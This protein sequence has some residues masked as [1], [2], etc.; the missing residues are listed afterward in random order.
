MSTH[1][2]IATAEDDRRIRTIPRDRAFDVRAV[3]RKKNWKGDIYATLLNAGWHWMLGM[4]CVVY[5]LINLVFAGAYY[6][7]TGGIHNAHPDSFLDVFFFSVQTL[8]TI[9]YGGMSPN[10]IIANLLVTIEAMVGFAYYGLVTG[11]MFAKFSRPT[12][13]ILFSDMAVIT[14]HNGHP[15]FMVRLANERHNGVVSAQAK[16]SLMRDEVTSEGQRM[17]RIHDLS[18]VRSEIPVLRLTWTIM[19][20]IDETSPLYGATS[21]QLRSNQ[22]EIIVSLMGL[23]E[24]FS[25][26]IH[27]R[28]S[29]VADE[30]ACNA[31]FEDV[32]TRHPNNTIEVRYD[33]FHTVIAD[34]AAMKVA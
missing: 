21:E 33:K 23:D 20:R 7:D 13:R 12:A 17:R 19:H 28:H 1:T 14:T 5:L 26:T 25:Q 18:L 16:L 24:T 31:H 15:H 34:D 29:Y 32:L 9:G 2:P 4:L 3:G 22:S 8:A 30:I 27:A 11:L 6:L 10:G